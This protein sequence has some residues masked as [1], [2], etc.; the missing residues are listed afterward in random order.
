MINVYTPVTEARRKGAP[1][2]FTES[3]DLVVECFEV[4]ASTGD[5]GADDAALAA[6]VDDLAEVV[7]NA[8]FTDPGTSPPAA[9]A[10]GW[11]YQF[12]AVDV[13]R[14]EIVLDGTSDGRRGLCR[15][16]FEVKHTAQYDPTPLDDL[17]DISIDLDLIED[18]EA[19]DGDVDAELDITDLDA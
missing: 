13:V 9:I 14:S 4:Q 11:L 6:K 15:M 18:G 10:L 17:T 12:E 2:M 16:M 3:H 7:Q 19:P 1:I 8:L 5:A